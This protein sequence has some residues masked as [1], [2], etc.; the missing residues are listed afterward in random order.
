M[1]PTTEIEHQK[2]YRA[3]FRSDIDKLCNHLWTIYT[4]RIDRIYGIDDET[5]CTY[6]TQLF[7]FSKQ[8][9]F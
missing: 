2:G 9:F 6:V 5:Y 8:D 7:T 1:A 4:Y 3:P